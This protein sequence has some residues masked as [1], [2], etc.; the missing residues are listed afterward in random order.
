MPAPAVVPPNGPRF[1]LRGR[2]VTMDAARTVLDDGVV[3]VEHGS[4]TAVQPAAAPPPASCGD[5]A[6]LD[7][8]ATI[9]P[10]LIELHNHLP[11]DVLPLWQV[12]KRY[13]DRG[14]WGG[15]A[16]PDYHRLVT[17][18]M[19]VLGAS[20]ALMP[21]VVRYVEGKALVNGTTT[22]QGVALFS[23]A[24]AR[25]MYRG[26]VRTVEAT[27]DP[28]LPEAV[29]RIADV[30]AADAQKFLARL[31]QPHKLLLHLAEGVDQAAREH[32][33]ALEYAPGQWAINHNLVG[34]HC[35]ALT[36]D[37]F[38]RMA[39]LGAAMVWS[40]LSNLLL[41]GAT[42]DVAAAKHAGLPMAL[43]SD[44]SV[45]G[46]KGLLG[47]LK[48]AR[49]AGQA[50]GGVFADDELVA[51]ATCGAA[52]ILGWDHALGS[53]APGL[54]AD[55]TA[56][57]GTSGDPYTALVDAADTDVALV[58]VGGAPRYGAT[59]LMRTLTSADPAGALETDVP[60]IPAGH[61][62]DL[63]Q[64]NADPAV[65]NLALGDA[66]A[67]VAKALAALPGQTTGEGLVAALPP[68]LVALLPAARDGVRGAAANGAPN[69]ARD[70]GE[71]VWRLALDEIRPTGAELRPR[72]PLRRGVRHADGVA[73]AAAAADSLL[74]GAS[75]NRA[76][77]SGPA[78]PPLPAD[79]AAGLS[80][81]GLDVLTAG[82][83]QGFL[84]ELGTEGNLPADYG[85]RLAALLA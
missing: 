19:S 53:L 34:I 8:G 84:A 85:R 22:S 37:D 16:N 42:A 79:A 72:L 63:Y 55:L 76:L 47:E 80:A 57:A 73:G 77:M 74:L 25:R 43:G 81:I 10:G 51:M 30:E 36:A 61:A 68:E 29:S 52:A 18:P 67:I 21:A 15:S 2:V 64:A 44:W 60:G 24:G 1:A 33:L 31:G 50:A 14:Q 59:A 46:S 13:G 9:Y 78:V 71:P 39:A 17:G 28:A 83:D 66:A 49:L 32:F 58:V 4:L 20:A 82:A 7:T 70:D 6:P 54:R 12:P 26:V 3:F 35:T 40:P 69:G 75:L 45:S 5:L 65:G 48:A 62:V 56:V 41:Y 27:D 23:D 38:A 11:Y